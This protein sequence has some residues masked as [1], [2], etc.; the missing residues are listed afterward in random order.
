MRFWERLRA[1]RVAFAASREVASKPAENTR[2]VREAG[3]RRLKTDMP[4][5]KITPG[6][7]LL[8]PADHTLILID[9]QSQMGVTIL[10]DE[11]RHIRVLGGC[12]GEREVERKQC[13]SA[14]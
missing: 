13:P 6:R 8:S 10:E 1:R 7:T 11:R 4:T 3:E 2:T 5:A 12:L 14:H 9:F